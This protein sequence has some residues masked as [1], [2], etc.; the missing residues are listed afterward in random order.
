MVS[1][2]LV[3]TNGRFLF[4]EGREL[5]D[6]SPFWKSHGCLYKRE[7][8]VLYAYNIRSVNDLTGGD[9]RVHESS[10]CSFSSTV[11]RFYGDWISKTHVKSEVRQRE[12]PHVSP[13][14]GIMGG[15]KFI[16]MRAGR[17]SVFLVLYFWLSRRGDW[18]FFHAWRRLAFGGEA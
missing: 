3:W 9:L 17:V 15:V 8:S 18:R 5:T 11:S 7:I 2:F 13:D 14:L 16:C 12:K 6:V 4:C 1:W 10:S